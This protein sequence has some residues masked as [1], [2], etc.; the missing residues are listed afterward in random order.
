MIVTNNRKVL[1]QYPQAVFIEG[2]FRDVLVQ[3]RDFVHLGHKLESHPLG[4][5]IGMMHSPVRSI[6]I[7]EHIQDYDELSQNIISQSIEKYDITMGTRNSKDDKR[8]DYETLDLELLD[9]AIEELERLKKG[10]VNAL[11]ITK[12]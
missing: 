3:V 5:S 10:D 1:A 8:S 12:R 9:A 11:R 4:A 2:G 7:S 6:L